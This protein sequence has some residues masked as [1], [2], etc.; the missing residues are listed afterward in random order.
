MSKKCVVGIDLG[1]TKIL[2]AVADLNGRFLTQVRLETEAKRGLT[3]VI[4]NIIN[5]V[6]I[7]LKRSKHTLKD[8][9]KICIGAPGPIIFKKGII[10]SPPN[11]PGWGK[12]DLKARLEKVFKKPV[13]VDNDAN[14]AALAEAKKGAGRG[15]KN[16]IYLTIS[17][18]IGAGIVLDGKVFRGSIGG[19]GEIG[20]TIIQKSMGKNGSMELLG[21]GTAIATQAMKS[22]TRN[23]L[24]LKLAHNKRLDITAEIV[25]KAAKKGDRLAR[26]IINDPSP[27]CGVLIEVVSV[28][29]LAMPVSSHASCV[30]NHP[31]SEK[32]S[33]LTK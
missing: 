8:V 5:S 2:T 29:I 18:G 3:V 16:V 11:L 26:K 27:V 22:V 33:S 6:V 13:I 30:S 14:L 23:S 25:A 10:V 24:M 12:V 9:Q 28:L 4:G 7:A 15:K 1:G 17:T 31:P 32:G 21:S 20:H 19:A